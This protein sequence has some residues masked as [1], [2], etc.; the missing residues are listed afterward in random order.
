MIPCYRVNL[1]LSEEF[2]VFVEKRLTFCDIKCEHFVIM[3]FERSQLPVLSFHKK[4][5][6]LL[7]AKSLNISKN[8]IYSHL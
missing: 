6:Q 4:K 8:V 5:G 2:L 7:V 3:I 1:F